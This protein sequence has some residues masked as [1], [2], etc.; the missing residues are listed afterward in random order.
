M[1][2]FLSH[3][4]EQK[5]RSEKKR[6]NCLKTA[7]MYIEFNAAVSFSLHM[8][9]MDR[10]WISRKKNDNSN[11]QWKTNERTHFTRDGKKLLYTIKK[12]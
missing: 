4:N 9:E 7:K 5:K 2:F 3:E 10:V 6:L 1:H 8:Y 11:I 12:N